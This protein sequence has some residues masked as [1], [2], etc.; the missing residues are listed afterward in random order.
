MFGDRVIDNNDGNATVDDLFY[1]THN[2]DVL[3]AGIDPEAH[4][5]ALAGA[6]AA[7]RMRFSIPRSI[8]DEPRRESRRHCTSRTP[9]PPAT[10]SEG[11]PRLPRST[12]R[13]IS[14][15]IPTYRGG[16]Q[17]AAALPC[18]M[19]PR[20]AASRPRSPVS[21][22][23]RR[24]RLGPLSSAQPRC[25]RGHRQSCSRTIA[26]SAIEGRRDS[27]ALFDSSGYARCYVCGR[28]VSGRQPA[29]SL[30]SVRLARGP[31]SVG[32]LRHVRVSVRQ[33]G[34]S[35]RRTSIR[36]VHSPARHAGGPLAHGGRRVGIKRF[37]PVRGRKRPGFSRSRGGAGQFKIS[38]RPCGGA[39]RPSG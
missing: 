6:R 19:A 4:H 23:K 29:R 9:R 36:F 26:R 3:S 39:L 18:A 17:S 27:N 37:T 13:S 1:L 16:R 8:G 32:G 25:G 22:R 33:S 2:R 15:T 34:C 14:R 10:G 7:I 31:R 30:P 20:K 21:D 38:S 35:A 28:N 12:C 24:F 5:A 11:A